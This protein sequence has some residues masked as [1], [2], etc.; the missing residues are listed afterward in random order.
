[1]NQ[2]LDQHLENLR[3]ALLQ[4]KPAGDEGFEGL[5]AKV[6]SY[7][8]GASFRL[9][10]S[11][12]QAGKD[13]G[14]ALDSSAVSFEAKRYDDEIPKEKIIS[15]IAE[16]GASNGGTNLWVLATTTEVA[17]QDADTC[18][19][20]GADRGIEVLILDWTC[21][22]LPPLGVVLAAAS[23]VTSNFLQSHCADAAAVKGATEALGAIKADASYPAETERLTLILRSASIG[24]PLAKSANRQWFEAVLS[25]RARARQAF[26]QPLCPAAEGGNAFW[27]RAAIEGRL[28]EQFADAT[29][30]SLIAV[31]G[32][33][34]V[35]KSWLVVRSWL[36]MNVAPLLVV[37]TADEVP[38]PQEDLEAAIIRKLI[39]QTGEAFSEVL[40]RRWRRRFRYWRM[41]A[42]A[43]E[44][45]LLVY[46]DGINQR[47]GFDWGR[48]MESASAML[49]ALGGRLVFSTRTAFYKARVADRM[50]TPV[51]RIDVKQWEQAEVVA[52]L[53]ARGID[54][55][56]IAEK[57][58]E[59]IRNPRLLGI[60]LEMLSDLKIE[61]IQ[62]LTVSRLLFEYI[63]I[64][65]RDGVTPLSRPDFVADLRRHAD[66]IRSRLASQ[67]RQD[68]RVFERPLLSPGSPNGVIDR[69][70][71]VSSER[72]F[73]ELDSDST[74]YE[75]D[76]EGLPLALGLSLIAALNKAERNGQSTAATLEAILEP[77]AAL[78]KT[79][80]IVQAAVLAACLDDKCPLETQSALIAAYVSLQNLD[81]N[82]FAEF[83]ALARVKPVAFMSAYEAVTA[84]GAHISNLDWLEAALLQAKSD[85]SAWAAMA[86][87]IAKWLS[88]YSLSPDRQLFAQERRMEPKKY[89]ARREEKQAKLNSSMSALSA[90]EAD[91]LCTKLVR[92]DKFDDY[93]IG[94]LAFRLLA[95][96][97]L[98]PFAEALRNWAFSHALNADLQEPR[99]QFLHL[100]QFNVRDWRETRDAIVAAST[101]LR[102]D[103]VSRVG[104]WALVT[105]LFATGDL[106]DAQEAST[107]S[108][109]LNSGL[110][111][112]ESD[113]SASGFCSTD[114]CDPSSAEPE[115]IEGIAE[116]YSGLD[117]SILRNGRGQRA[118]DL[119]FT[120]A[121][122]GM[123]RF[124]LD[125]A[126]EVHRRFASDIVRRSGESLQMG[127]FEVENH[128]SILN[129]EIVTEYLEKIRGLGSGELVGKKV[130][131]DEW[132]AAQELMLAVFP[133]MSGEEQLEFLLAR[134]AGESHLRKLAEVLRP[135]DGSFFEK[136][137]T[138]AIVDGD[139]SGQLRTLIYAR[140]T[141]TEVSA[142]SRELI[143]GQLSSSDSLV[144][145]YVLAIADKL[146][147]EALLKRVVASG[148]SAGNLSQKENYY[149]VWY[150]SSALLRAAKRGLIS[151]E[152][153]LDR[154]SL[155][156]YGYAAEELG[157]DAARAVA[158]RLDAALQ[159]AGAFGNFPPLPDI[160]QQQSRTPRVT[161]ALYSVS[162]RPEKLDVAATFKRLAETAESF[163]ERQRR[164]NAAFDRFQE[165][166]TREGANLVIEYI[167]SR[168]ADAI[169]SAAPELAV[170]WMEAFLA[171]PERALRNVHNVALVIAKSLSASAPEKSAML[172]ERL[173]RSTPFVRITG[174]Q[175]TLSLDSV[176]L[177]LADDN[178]AINAL[179]AEKLDLA[180]T[181]QEV[182]SMVLAALRGGKD[183]LLRDYVEKQIA[184]GEPSRIARAL[185]V[186]GFR[187][188]NDHSG[189]ILSR[190]DG[191]RGL[192]GRALEA[193]R[194]A[195]ERNAWARK[196]YADIYASGSGEA[197]WR[198]AM[199]FTKIVDARFNLWDRDPEG[200]SDALGRFFPGIEDRMERR[201]KSWADK[202]GKTL[203]GG[204]AP[205]PIFLCS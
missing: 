149:E 95:G 9:A 136:C 75:L 205:E 111:W 50:I 89:A 44:R 184:S 178:A 117:V 183:G 46:V 160:E 91:L 169:A 92:V 56:D 42:T 171:R 43:D 139:T 186:C 174:G 22:G 135:V 77:I 100:I 37:F 198:S 79:A 202:R 3:Q 51:C 118:E 191:A 61:H 170:R 107:L 54:A 106:T 97:A 197:F 177:W 68:I 188:E 98:A 127:V 99:D 166:L 142:S 58:L 12:T 137:L 190:Y 28:Q 168:G 78:D 84:S 39:V 108:D 163:D 203:F 103:S 105:L 29:S 128:A 189:E 151:N 180:A 132:I 164:N 19:K 157:P 66:E 10:K 31:L 145:A 67:R 70:V 82:G 182:A 194:Y 34:G 204:K 109:T 116:R 27:P 165:A 53:Q 6:F 101:A 8:A 179:R 13:G 36:D 146:D 185:M 201:I 18:K 2:P 5:L 59:S 30:N 176:C 16:L 121:R 35:G 126:I 25:D 175:G 41:T 69:L 122:P 4:L 110:Q 120:D 62:E 124:R 63:R 23:N 153:V 130:N 55:K 102:G 192:I 115:N 141:N 158:Q 20:V 167:G 80:Q 138:R 17:T 88:Y 85:V 193:A 7:I 11:G 87:V 181:D 172:F 125:T 71:A 52:I 147:E 131:H 64:S 60:A 159:K 48:W 144:R 90:L 162:D 113:R 152:D 156:F 173:A 21:A 24:I 15:K 40:E 14:S 38:A 45:R 47:S 86:D 123:A 94:Y 76:E 33:E 199:I 143:E 49:D 112:P 81:E 129:Q 195:Y 119:F 57:V 140:H 96:K 65:V 134:P 133:H 26:G 32:E 104:K 1:M 196:W 83:L 148:W 73:R 200:G 187:D 114:P 155:G 150:G 72:F 154:I 74:L 93:R 161:P